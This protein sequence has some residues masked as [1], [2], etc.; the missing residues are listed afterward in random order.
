[1]YAVDYQEIR[2]VAFGIDR[3][4]LGKTLGSWEDMWHLEE[5]SSRRKKEQVTFTTGYWSETAG[6]LFLK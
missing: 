2:L 3:M 5:T 6:G 1:M 4:T